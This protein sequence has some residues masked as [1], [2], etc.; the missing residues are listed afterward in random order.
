MSPHLCNEF[1][2]KEVRYKATKSFA[3]GHR[4]SKIWTYV[5]PPPRLVGTVCPHIRWPG[6]G[7]WVGTPPPRTVTSSTCTTKRCTSRLLG[8]YQLA[9]CI[10][11]WVRGLAS[12]GRTEGGDQVAEVHCF[13][14]LSCWTWTFHL[15]KKKVLLSSFLLAPGWKIQGDLRPPC[16]RQGASEAAQI[17]PGNVLL[18]E[19]I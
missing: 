17:G 14:T 15:V 12:G 3:Q 1:I 13:S 6:R 7:C 9:P 8:H 2:G 4:A 11:I 16:E 18:M 5:C 19:L 10:P